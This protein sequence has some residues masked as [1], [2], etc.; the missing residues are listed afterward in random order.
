VGKYQ[1]TQDDLIINE[2]SLSDA[3]LKL[4]WEI[5]AREEAE[6]LMRESENRLRSAL[7]DSPYPTMLHTEGG[8]ILNINNAWLE[9]CGYSLSEISSLDDWISKLFRAEANQVIKEIRQLTHQNR[10]FEGYY[11]IYTKK[12]ETKTWHF[13]WTLLPEGSDEKPLVLTNAI[14]L[15]SLIEAETALRKSEE[16]L[17]RFSLVTNDGIWDWDLETDQVI[18][19]PRYYTMVGYQINEFPHHLDEFRKRVHPDDVDLVFLKAEDHLSGKNPQFSV[20]FRFLRKDGDWQWILGRGKIVE[21][22]ENGQPLRFVGT[23]TDI[24]DRKLAEEELNQQQQQLENMVVK[25]TK[26]L[27]E[28]VNE[29]EKL[30]K[31]LSNILDDYQTANEKLSLVS[32]DLSETYQELESFTYAVSNDLQNPLRIIKDVSHQLSSKDLSKLNKK[33]I[34]KLEE[35]FEN[36]SRMDRLV[37]D[38]LEL[39]NLSKQEVKKK[40]VNTK[41][42]VNQVLKDFSDEI[43]TRQIKMSVKDLP[44]CLADQEMLQLVFQNLISNAVKFTSIQDKAEITIGHQ[45]DQ[46]A[47]KVIYYVQDNGIGFNMEDQEKVFETF[48]RLHEQEVFHG[49]GTGLALAKRVINKHGGRIWVE[50]QEKKGATFYFDLHRS[51][52]DEVD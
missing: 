2:Q 16:D 3:N 5:S 33:D 14:D 44:G 38:L 21:Q 34:K 47:D 32:Q 23:H 48:H 25:R 46:S 31:A 6:V 27:E 10:K 4:L 7:M 15:T 28:R 18:F 40:R 45:P 37:S 17:F 11:T 9:L 19:D 51:Q 43:N 35:I 42:L 39:S 29:V 49:T 1:E 41:K 22:D 30:N 36:T 52:G 12:G 13:R 24:S 26:Q 50:A 8:D 20:E